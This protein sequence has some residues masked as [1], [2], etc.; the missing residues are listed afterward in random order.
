M[1]KQ[2]LALHFSFQC[3]ELQLL[4]R[5][6]YYYVDLRT[7]MHC[8]VYC[9]CYVEWWDVVWPRKEVRMGEDDLG[10][11]V[12][13]PQSTT[14]LTRAWD[15]LIILKRSRHQQL[16]TAGMDICTPLVSLAAVFCSSSSSF[17]FSLPGTHS[18][19]SSCRG[20]RHFS[21]NWYLYITKQRHWRMRCN[22]LVCHKI[23]QFLNWPAW[24]FL[25]TTNLFCH[26]ESVGKY[27]L[28]VPLVVVVFD[29]GHR[30]VCW[31]LVWLTRFKWW[32]I[33]LV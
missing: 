19:S 30:S 31:L 32:A 33:T 13:S 26:T 28:V 4:Q 18:L 2:D 3:T 16:A 5:S 17:S 24:D 21:D 7:K 27:F 10:D 14:R 11:A 15:K 8:Q 23:E 1:T 29:L 22:V 25:W 9:G 20:D 12:C 6:T